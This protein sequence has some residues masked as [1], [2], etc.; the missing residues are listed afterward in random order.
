M[1]RILMLV[2]AS[3]LVLGCF[4][5]YA[6][7]DGTYAGEGQ[8]NNGPVKVAVTVANGAIASV[9]VVE[10]GETPGICDLAIERIP[11][12]IVDGQTLAV[13]AVSGATNSSNAILTAVE[14]AVTEAGA[15]IEAL[16]KPVEKNESDIV[17]TERE[18]KALVIG[19]GGSGMAA[20]T[21]LLEQ[22]VD[23]LLIDKMAQ[24]G[25]AT[26]L[27]GALINGGC[28]NQQAIRGSSDT[29][30]T[31]F[32]DLMKYGSF[33]NDARMTWIFANNTGAAVDW[34]HDT[35]GVEFEEK[36]NY[37]PEH[38]ND[39]AL[40]PLGKKPGYLTSTQEAHYKE[41]GGELLTETKAEHLLFEDGKVVGAECSTPEGKLVIHADAV[42]LATGGYGASV[43]LRD[44]S[45]TSVLFYGSA[46]STGDG[47]YLAEEVNAKTHYM[48]YLKSYPQGIEKPLEGGNITP[49]GT[50]YIANAYISPL[51]SQAATLNDGA[52]YVNK[53][54]KRCMNENMDFVSIKK[55][56]MKQEDKTIY[57]LL[58]QKGY[59]NWMNSMVTSN[60]IPADAVE[61]WLDK[62]PESKPVFR[63]GATL[64]EL[65]EKAGIDGAAL[66]ATVDHFN[67]MVAAGEDTDFGRTEMSVPLDKD[68]NW[69]IIEQRLR[70]AT[71]LGGLKTSTSFEVYDVNEKVIPGLYACG[72][73]VG[74]V[75]GDE[76]MPSCMVGWAITSGRLTGFSVAEALANAGK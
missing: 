23:V 40:Y 61:T 60:S 58:D 46:A 63:R 3:L 4:G 11:K 21:T 31:I 65:G 9:E 44:P 59:D 1:K 43:A 26:S 45:L 16:K 29:V 72:E 27:T 34:L 56:T 35:V 76:S 18:V 48:Q 47:I 41:I 53:A 49:D 50:R 57:L 28:S 74:G 24:A 32:M 54:G 12:A 36:L 64:E 38:T 68:G 51:A 71:S 62:G 67:E 39:R 10:H 55:A 70:M 14:A 69:Y 6:M 66:A 15:D 30:E 17:V 2:L 8:G 37:F 20:A 5:A 7:T 73:V 52:I 75:H 25:G 13:D 22:G 33:L 19:A 42:V